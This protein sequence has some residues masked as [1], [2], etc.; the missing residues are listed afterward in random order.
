MDVNLLEKTELWVNHITLDNVNLTALAQVVAE[1]LQ[2]DKEDVLVVDV[3]PNHI[4]LDI[5]QKEVP[6]DHILGKE[7]D[8][9]DALRGVD[10]VTLAEDAYTHS[11]GVLGVINLPQEKVKDFSAKVQ[12]MTES[13]ASKIAKRAIVFPT[14]FELEEGLIEDTNSPFI[15]N[16]LEKLGYSVEIG[17][18]IKDNVYDITNH[19]EEALAKAYGLIVTTGGVGAEDKDHTVE[20]VLSVDPSA[21]TPYIV[22]FKKGTGRH[23]KDGV[24][25]TVGQVGPSLI[26]SLPGPNDEVKASINVLAQC[27]QQGADKKDIAEKIAQNLATL[28]AEKQHAFHKHN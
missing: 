26:V 25:I 14:G 20:G 22:K 27:L 21:Q 6:M 16:E 1:V 24:K 8:L 7:K 19:L 5:M 18:I 12:K 3:R 4:T 28:L 13:M 17:N 9:L 15:K 23:V 2:I 11:N 10:G